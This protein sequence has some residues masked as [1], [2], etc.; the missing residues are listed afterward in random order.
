MFAQH[1]KIARRWA[2]EQKKSKGRKSFKTMPDKLHTDKSVKP[3]EFKKQAQAEI[4]I[5]MIKAA[6]FR[7]ELEKIA[8][9]SL[10]PFDFNI[11][12]AAIALSGAANVGKKAS[13][14]AAHA[15]SKKGHKIKNEELAKLLGGTTGLLGGI[16]G[17]ILGLKYR[18]QLQKILS[19]LTKNKTAMLASRPAIPMASTVLG[20]AVAGAGTGVLVSVRG[21]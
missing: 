8:I 2:D 6:A 11:P 10:S 20:G 18:P 5:G 19:K 3:S 21:K 17:M 4:T 16:G 13:G 1:P 15:A 7:E 12:H 9:I 14:L